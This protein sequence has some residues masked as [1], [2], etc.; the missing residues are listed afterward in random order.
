MCLSGY[1]A[2]NNVYVVDG[3]IAVVQAEFIF[4]IPMNIFVFVASTYH[5]VLEECWLLMSTSW[6]K[7]G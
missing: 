7:R 2:H 1:S 5:V 4:S 3:I 6:C